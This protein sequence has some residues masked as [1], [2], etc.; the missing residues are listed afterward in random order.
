[1]GLFRNLAPD[2]GDWGVASLDIVRADGAVNAEVSPQSM[3]TGEAGQIDFDLRPDAGYDLSGGEL[4]ILVPA[5]W[6]TPQAT[7]P[8]GAGYVAAEATSGAAIGTLSV[9]NRTITVPLVT[10][11]GENRLRVA[12]GDV[13]QGGG[14]ACSAVGRRWFG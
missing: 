5:G 4:T 3:G 13:S 14:G 12:Y 9:S 2:G 1:M 11:T 7:D 6:T 8:Q 10:F